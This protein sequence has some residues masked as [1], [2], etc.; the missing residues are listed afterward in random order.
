[1]LTRTDAEGWRISATGMT[2]RWT[3]EQ[4]AEVLNHLQNG[5]TGL[6]ELTTEIN[7][8]KYQTFNDLVQTLREM[9][10]RGR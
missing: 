10:Q 7:D 4:H 1:M 6:G 9:F 2:K 5:A 8:G 3:P